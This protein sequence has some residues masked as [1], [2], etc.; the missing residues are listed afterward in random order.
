MYLIYIGGL[1]L[2]KIHPL[3]DAFVRLHQVDEMDCQ[4]LNMNILVM[5]AR[6]HSA[7]TEA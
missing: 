4:T 7:F 1:L 2:R 5:F 6:M 3:S